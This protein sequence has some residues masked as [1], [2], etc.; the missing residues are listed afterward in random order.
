MQVCKTIK[1]FREEKQNKK[2]LE[3]NSNYF[4]YMFYFVVLKH[5]KIF[6]CF[7]LKGFMLPYFI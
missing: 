3:K 5:L 7:E 6:I 1:N 4:I 2:A